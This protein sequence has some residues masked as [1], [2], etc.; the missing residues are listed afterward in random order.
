MALDLGLGG[1]RWSCPVSAEEGAGAG[2]AAAA[3]RRNECGEADLEADSEFSRL[4]LIPFLILVYWRQ[5]FTLRCMVL[6][7][8]SRVE[9]SSSA[10]IRSRT[11]DPETGEAVV[12]MRMMDCVRDMS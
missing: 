7:A 8:F 9:A 3:A 10:A 12:A 2:A 11:S 6:T 4:L 5:N 1:G